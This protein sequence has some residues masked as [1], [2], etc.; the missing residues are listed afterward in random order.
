MNY[1]IERWLERIQ[2][3]MD[4]QKAECMEI[5]TTRFTR[6]DIISLMVLLRSLKE[7]EEEK[8][9]I[10]VTMQENILKIVGNYCKAARMLHGLTATEIAD[11]LNCSRQN[12]SKFENGYNNSAEILLY[13]IA[14]LM[15]YQSLYRMLEEVE[16]K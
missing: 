4:V 10:G 13:Y 11:K 1:D 14:H 3:L 6:Q 9:K 5:I 16:D 15:D 12:I 7:L 2:N 8:I